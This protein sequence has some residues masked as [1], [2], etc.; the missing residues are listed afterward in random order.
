[1]KNLFKF[2][3]KL[4][5]YSIIPLVSFLLLLTATGRLDFSK[6]EYK[7]WDVNS[8]DTSIIYMAHGYAHTTQDQS[9]PEKIA[10]YDPELFIFGGDNVFNN[11]KDKD[12]ANLNNTITAVEDEGIPTLLIKGNHDMYKPGKSIEE[13]FLYRD[14]HFGNNVIG[15]INNVYIDTTVMAD[16]SDGSCGIGNDQIEFL[17]KT[18]SANN[19]RHVILYLHHALWENSSYIEPTN[20]N[21]SNDCAGD[22]WENEIIPIID[23][24]IDVVISSDGGLKTNHSEVI[25]EDIK[26][27]V[28]GSDRNERVIGEEDPDNPSLITFLRVTTNNGELFVNP[29]TMTDVSLVDTKALSEITTYDVQGLDEKKLKELYVHSPSY[30]KEDDWRVKIEPQEVLDFIQQPVKG[31]LGDD[32]VEINIRGNVGN[33]WEDFKKSWDIN[34]EDDQRQVKLII[35]SDRRYI[36]QMYVQKLSEWFDV[37]TPEISIARLVINDIDFGL[38]LQYEDF[39]KAFI[40]LNG[41]NSDVTPSKN[42]FIDH[43]GSYPINRDLS[44]TTGDKQDKTYQQNISQIEFTANNINN[45]FDQDSYARWLAVQ[46][47]LGD[48]HQNMSDNFRYFI[49]RPTGRYIMVNW[50]SYLER[51]D[52]DKMI[53]TT[54]FN[55]AFLENPENKKLFIS[56]ISEYIENSEDLRKELVALKDEYLPVFLNDTNAEASKKAISRSLENQLKNFDYN[57]VQ[58]QE[59]LKNEK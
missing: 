22:F 36:N 39:D 46:T 10:L 58:I 47:I 32:S 31:N 11:G 2:D 45:Y 41:Y 21:V 30:K 33:H 59:W 18:I 43:L 16:D 19:S 50:D 8:D 24:K 1:M 9:W 52:T 56:Y 20:A 15:D 23:K 38:Y 17:E 3:K 27:I 12:I 4:L 55:T 53:N 28:S 5:L 49:D 57:N 37:P 6:S 51:V 29:I 34:F 26:Y 48:K 42:L 7:V 54:P 35:P 25:K 44:N 13:G 40:E 14:K